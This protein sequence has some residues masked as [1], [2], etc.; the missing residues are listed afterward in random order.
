MGQKQTITDSPQGRIL[1]TGIYTSK[2]YLCLGY[3]GY[4][5]NFFLSKYEIIPSLMAPTNDCT[6]LQV[7]K[8]LSFKIKNVYYVTS[9]INGN[10]LA[11]D[12]ILLSQPNIISGLGGHTKGWSGLNNLSQFQDLDWFDLTINLRL[13]DLFIPRSQHPY[14]LNDAKT[15]II[16]PNPELLSHDSF[17][18]DKMLF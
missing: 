8:G 1:T 18:L 4:A 3:D 2:Q 14:T 15:R 17:F 13:Q 9:P 12:C 7:A 5:Q 11:A 10:S 6:R 16:Q